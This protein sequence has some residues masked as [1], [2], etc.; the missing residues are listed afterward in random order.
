MW[1]K[2]ELFRWLFDEL[3]PD[4]NKVRWNASE[5]EIERKRTFTESSVEALGIASTAVSRHFDEQIKDDWV[6]ED[7][8]LYPEQMG[9]L[10]DFHKHSISLFVSPARGYDTIV[11]TRWSHNDLIQHILDTSTMAKL[12][13]HNPFG[14]EVVVR[15]AIENG[16]PIF[17]IS[18][19]G[20]PEFTR[21]H[22][23]AILETQGPYVFSCQYLNDP[24]HENARSFQKNW[25][26]YYETTPDGLRCYTTV[27]PATERGDCFSAICTI[28]MHHTGAIYV[29]EY[30]KANLGTDELVEEIIRHHLL[31]KSRVGMETVVFQKVLLHP[32]REAMR[33]Y[34]IAFGVKDL[35]PIGNQRKEFR[36]AG[37]LQPAFAS[38]KIFLRSDMAEL[39]RELSWFPA[40]SNYDLLDALSYAV[41]MATK[42]DF[43]AKRTQSPLDVDVIM[44][45]LERKGRGQ[46][47]GVFIWNRQQEDS[48]LGALEHMLKV[49]MKP[50]FEKTEAEARRL[51]GVGGQVRDN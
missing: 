14:Y 30:T 40:I 35:H 24:V 41:Q 28:G 7:H 16:E 5:M 43:E 19:L 39:E 50:P 23:D 13:S 45:E 15:A 48:D 1:E 21:E 2:N 17:P 6:N 36:I 20:E 9:K 8:V 31:Y 11:G 18:G 42:P 3:I 27:D 44:E 29:L 49:L 10:I 33:R 38:G 46:S 51:L 4:F 47:D 25:N 12:G 22:L 26:R 37:I 34:G 32:L